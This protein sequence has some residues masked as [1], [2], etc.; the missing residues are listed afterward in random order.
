MAYQTGRTIKETLDAISRRG[1]VLPAIQRE[2]V[3]SMQ[4]ICRL[5]DSLMQGYPFG[6]F[7]YW[8]IQPENSAKHT[9]FDFVQ[10]YHQRYNPHCPRSPAM[11]QRNLTAVL[12][13]QQRLTALN[14]GFRGSAAWKLPRKHWKSQDAF[15]TRRLHLDLTWPLPSEDETGRMYR[16]EFLTEEQA[17]RSK[18][19]EYWFPV[20]RILKM[21][22]IDDVMKWVAKHNVAPGAP[23]LGRLY[24]VTHIDPVVV[25]YEEKGQELD[26]VLQIFIRMNSGGTTLSHSDLL[27][28][29]AVAEWKK[30][31]A[32]QEIRTLV[33]DLNRIGDGF[34]FSK[35]FVLKAGLM[36]CDI[37][38]VAFKVDNFNAQNMKA[39]E[40][41]WGRVKQSLLAAVELVS[42][43]GFNA[44]TLRADSAV[45]PIAYYIHIRDRDDESL[46]DN[47]P[48][49]IRKWLVHS[50]L[51]ASGIWGSGLDTLLTALRRVIQKNHESFPAAAIREEMAHRGRS[52]SFNPEEIE[53]L[54]DLKYGNARVFSLLSLLFPSIDVT[55]S[56]FHLDH[57][58]PRVRFGKA[59]L[60]QAGVPEDEHAKFVDRRDRLA[61]LQLLE[62]MANGGKRAR[63]P[64]DWLNEMDPEKRKAYCERHVLG[65]VP[66]R[67]VDFL[68]FYDARRCALRK[69]IAALLGTSV[70]QVHEGSEAEDGR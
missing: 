27:L 65:D 67:M 46:T 12:D 45:L 15:P 6:T 39:L 69:K 40:K 57:I 53:D 14:I 66:D 34:S 42:D 58:F 29:V 51:K 23:A 61:N 5:F 48:D 54:V 50:I 2:F 11:P 24:Q 1:L 8:D 47:D 17:G 33:D 56:H 70:N 44:S 35:D 32:R 16:F 64:S 63:M 18:D 21:T 20:S 55:R 4:Q 68:S 36:L 43:F 59:K 9:Y 52:L 10:D 31:D 49:A 3:W 25:C 62:G 30:R 19:D 22:G 37:G 7:L 41:N 38:S 60:R 26:K 28:S 13:G